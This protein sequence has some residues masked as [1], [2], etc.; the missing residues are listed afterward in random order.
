ME[1][2]PVEITRQ[3]Y[4]VTLRAYGSLAVWHITDEHWQALREAIKEGRYDDI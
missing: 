3:S 1:P 4:W 2:L